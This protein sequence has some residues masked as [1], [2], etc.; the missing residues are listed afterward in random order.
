METSIKASY[1]LPQF[2]FKVTGSYHLVNNFIY[3]DSLAV[4]RQT[5]VPISIF[6]LSV[7]KDFKFGP[8]HLDNVV[9]VQQVSEDVL[10]LPSFYTK[11]SLY[12]AGKWFKVL[13]VRL[14]FDLRLS[15][16]YFSNY[17]YPLTGQFILQ[18][19]REVEAYPAVDGFFSMRVSKFRAFF[20]WE[21]MT[22]L[23]INDRLFYQSAFYPHQFSGYRFGIYWVLK[24]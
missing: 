23:L 4:P 19:R 20:K 16:A 17:Y 6:Q 3:Y 10:R 13:N 24:G 18:N 2:K 5:G 8:I 21:N 1:S 22:D 12:Y 14:G 15:N 9:S 7:K 11:N